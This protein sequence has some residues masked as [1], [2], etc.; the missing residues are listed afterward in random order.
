RLMGAAAALATVGDALAAA[1][2][3][4]AAAGVPEPRADA[5]VLLARALSTTRAGLVVVARRPLPEAAARGFATLV[6]RR[7]AREPLRYIVGERAFWSLSLAVDRR[8]LVPRPV[9]ALVVGPALGPAPGARRGPEVGTGGGAGRA[10]GA[11][12][13]GR[14]GA[15]RA[16]AGRLA[17]N[18]GGGGA[19]GRGAPPGGGKR[20]LCPHRGGP[21]SRRHRARA[22]AALGRGRM[23]TIVIRGGA[24]LEGEVVVSGSKNAALPLLFATLLT[25]ERSVVRNVPALAD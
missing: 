24:E 9:P 2:A 4:L 14:R 18:G 16:R 17:R 7:A 12:P 6:G 21:R 1:I 22:R 3:R 20:T 19:G 25:R 5:E 8:V 10:R 11:R 23:D 15:A 13:A